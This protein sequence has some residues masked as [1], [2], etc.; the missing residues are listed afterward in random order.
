[1]RRSTVVR[2]SRLA[3]GAIALALAVAGVARLAAPSAG[4]AAPVVTGTKLTMLEP[5]YSGATRDGRRYELAAAT[6]LYPAG[7]GD[8]I[9]L[10]RPRARLATTNGTTLTLTAASGLLAYGMDTVA[11]RHDVVLAVGAREIRLTEARIDLR[12]NTVTSDAPF[13]INADGRVILG[14]RLEVTEAGQVAVV[15][16]GVL[17]RAGSVVQFDSIAV[18]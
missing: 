3:A 15:G 12:S 7:G 18:P 6:A 13:E 9:E 17:I 11:L 4:V 2:S 14:H 16:G 10:D 5:K 1:M 8:G